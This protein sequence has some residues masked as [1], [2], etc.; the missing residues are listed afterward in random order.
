M[1]EATYQLVQD[2]FHQ[3][4]SLTKMFRSSEPKAQL[5]QGRWHASRLATARSRHDVVLF[6]GVRRV[7]EGEKQKIGGEMDTWLVVE[8]THLDNMRKI[9]LDHFHK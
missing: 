4:Y 7:L 1:G 2:F 6:V 8:P 5:L 3:Q 9:K